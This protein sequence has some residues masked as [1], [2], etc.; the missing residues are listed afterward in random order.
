MASIHLRVSAM[1][2]C[3][4]GSVFFHAAHGVAHDTPTHVLIANSGRQHADTLGVGLPRTACQLLQYR[5][6]HVVKNFADRFAF[7]VM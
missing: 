1:S 5:I 6:V 3:T 4:P 7:V 2:R